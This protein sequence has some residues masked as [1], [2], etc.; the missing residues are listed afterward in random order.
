VIFTIGKTFTFAASHQLTGVPDGHQCARLH[1]HNYAITLTI[2]ADHLTG[3]GWVKDYGDLAPFGVYLDD[4]YD[5]RHLNDA[6]DF[7]P[8]AEQLAAHLAN[9]AVTSGVVPP[10][11]ITVTVTV[12]ESP[13]TTAAC[14]IRLGQQDRDL[15]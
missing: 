8:T 6:V 3:P 12:N 13:K 9:W 1:G 5:H 4:H 2:T 11:T 15:V 14:T 10:N 7:N